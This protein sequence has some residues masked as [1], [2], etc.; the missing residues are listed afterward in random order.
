LQSKPGEMMLDIVTLNKIYYT[1]RERCKGC[2]DTMKKEGFIEA[3]KVVN[4]YRL[5][6][7]NKLKDDFYNI[8]L[9]NMY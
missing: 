5:S 2:D 7:F 1:L 9:P 3:V 4:N 6:E 8:Q